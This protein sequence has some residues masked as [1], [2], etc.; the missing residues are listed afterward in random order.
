MIL[1][2]S[3]AEIISMMMPRG[4]RLVRERLNRVDLLHQKDEPRA[5]VNR[6]SSSA[7]REIKS[8]ELLDEAGGVDPS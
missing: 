4:I 1:L 7:Q 5:P 8:L 2:L 6:R 3:G